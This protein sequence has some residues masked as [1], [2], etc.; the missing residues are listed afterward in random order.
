M[1]APSLTDAS[2][3]VGSLEVTVCE[4]SYRDGRMNSAAENESCCRLLWMLCSCV[5][6]ADSFVCSSLRCVTGSRSTA[7][8]AAM[9]EL[10][11][12]P[13]A[14]PEIVIGAAAEEPTCSADVDT[15]QTYLRRPSLAS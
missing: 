10:V 6:S 1:P 13:E 12:R 7:I 4:L 3:R 2:T 11:S 14:R 15:A 9:I 8:S 5:C